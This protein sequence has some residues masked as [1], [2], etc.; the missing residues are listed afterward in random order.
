MAGHAHTVLPNLV[1]A[2]AQGQ[3]TGL[4]ICAPLPP[5]PN[6]PLSTSGA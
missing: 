6:A 3:H 4:S 5:P 1:P 2:Y